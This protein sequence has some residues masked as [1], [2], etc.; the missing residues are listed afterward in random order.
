MDLDVLIFGTGIAG[1]WTLGRL[2]AAGIRVAALESDSVGSQQTVYSQGIVH[3]GAK[4]LFGR[5]EKASSSPLSAMP[6]LWRDCINGCGE[7]RLDR[8]GLLSESH[9]LWTTGGVVSQVTGAIAG[10][11]VAGDATRITNRD[12]CP[13][14]LVPVLGKGRVYRLNEPVFDV[15]SLLTDLRTSFQSRIR[16]YDGTLE[17]RRATNS[18]KIESV[19]VTHPLTGNTVTLRARWYVLA[20]GA[21]NEVLSQQFLNAAAPKTQRRPLHMV[22]ARGPG[23]LPVFA[24]CIGSRPKPLVT[25]TTHPVDGGPVWYLGG[26]LAE[27]GVGRDDTRQI[28]HAIDTL[29]RT[30]PGARLDM[31]EWSSVP[32]D[33]A[34]PA[35]RHGRRPE[36]E[37]VVCHGNVLTIWPTKLALAPRL[38]AR[39][40]DTVAHDAS[41]VTMARTA[42]TDWNPFAAFEPWPNP[43]VA[44]PPWLETKRRWIS[45]P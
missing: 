3:G 40:V 7:L 38:A 34:E 4:Y 28:Q 2:A 20:A 35:Q 21:G 12:D 37:C 14:A 11:V 5:A 17:V 45:A 25:I 10:K 43:S 16:H 33:R 18:E 29:H 42:D 24:H 23:L 27:S 19:T 15:P 26:E 30:L 8:T 32:I 31:T 13:E 9:Y 36:H 22:M 44:V 39:L 41:N 1:L 6:R